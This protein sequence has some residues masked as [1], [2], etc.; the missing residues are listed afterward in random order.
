[1]LQRPQLERYQGIKAHQLF[2]LVTMFILGSAI[3]FGLGIKEAKQDAWLAFLVAMGVGLLLF[4]IYA[5]L[6][7]AYPKLTL[8]QILQQNFGTWLG[9]FLGFLYVLYFFYIAVRDVGDFL[10]L[11]KI[12]YFPQSSLW[13]TGALLMVGILY[14]A[15][16]GVENLAGA[17]LVLFLLTGLL[18]VLVDLLI[19]I[20]GEVVWNRLE[21]LLEGGVRPIFQAVFPNLLSFPFGEVIAFTMLLSFYTGKPQR[22]LLA[23]RLG[24]LAGG[25]GLTIATLLNIV[26]LGDDIAVR[27]PFPYLTTLSKVELGRF[28]QRLDLAA[29]MVL[30]T[31]GFIKISVF[32]QA[33]LIGIRQLFQ[34]KK[35][36][37]LLIV[38]MGIIM[39]YTA[40]Q[41]SQNYVQHMEV[42]FRWV[43]LYLHVPFQMVIPPLLL[44][45]HLLRKRLS[46]KGS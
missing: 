14:A 11:L 35:R 27:S 18:L 34:I 33:A 38:G 22:A 24:I 17:A 6:Y 44:L 7:R 30:V 36:N 46:K 9:W 5:W 41:L 13:I 8:V 32:F 45:V 21:P 12:A 3:V 42:G 15:T 23:S 20:S 40:V 19:V 4:Q 29:I 39:L 1:M 2:G 28:L 31:C 10:G 43:P 26:V 25:F 37:H 16:K